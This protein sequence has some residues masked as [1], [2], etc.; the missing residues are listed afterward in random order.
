MKPI[1]YLQTNP[2]WSG[3]DYSTKGEKTTIGASGCGPSCMAMVIATLKNKAVTPKDTCAWALSHGFKAPNQGTYYSYFAPQGKAYDISIAQL[4]GSNLYGKT[5]Q[6]ASDY[7]T[8]ALAEIKKGNMVICCMGKGNWTRSG[9]FI[10]W[11]GLDKSGKV[12]INDPNSTKIERTCAKLSLLQSQVKYYF[13]VDVDSCKSHSDNY[14]KV[15]EKYSFNDTTMAYLEAYQ[16]ADSLFALML[17]EDKNLQKYQ[18]NTIL[19]ILDYQYG[20]QIFQKLTK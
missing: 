3:I 12:L 2:K 15:K 8:K 7:H 4:N 13:I 19:Y 14:Y 9:H 16:Y 20:K 5:S 17:Q 1:S 11:Y 18:L 10:L 6:W